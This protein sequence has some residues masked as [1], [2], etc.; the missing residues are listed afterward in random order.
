MVPVLLDYLQDRS[1]RSHLVLAAADGDRPLPDGPQEVPARHPG[2]HS[3]QNIFWGVFERLVSFVRI[4]DTLLLQ[5]CPL[6][7][8][9]FGFASGELQYEWDST[10]LSMDEALELAQYKVQ[11]PL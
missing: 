6:E 11:S 5:S 1:E 8:G 3:R 7:I 2:Q 9:S 4:V 10:P